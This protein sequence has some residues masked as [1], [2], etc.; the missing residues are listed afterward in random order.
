MPKLVAMDWNALFAGLNRTIASRAELLSRGATGPALTVA[1]RRR[2]LVRLRRD[3]YALPTAPQDIRQAVRVGGRLTCTSALRHYGI[4]ALDDGF[5][6]IHVCRDMSRLRHPRRRAEPLGDDNRDGITLHWT[7]LAAPES[8]SEVAVGVVDALVCAVR[9]QHPWFAVASL[10]NAL[11]LG[12]ID[13]DGVDAVFRRLPASH[14]HLR[15]LVDGRAESGQESVL[16][17]IVREAGLSYELQVTFDGIGRVDM[18]VEGRLVLEADSRLAHDGWAKQVRDRSRDLALAERG[19][20]T[21]RP[22]YQHIL[23]TPEAVRDAILGLLS[24]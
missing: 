10:D 22:L 2:D 6:Q 19:L 13:K 8:A 4:F 1:V 11:F 16:R 18:V 24:S 20:M 5:T 14:Q 21:L 17:M 3:H 15:A 7:G 23:F 9:C 12:V